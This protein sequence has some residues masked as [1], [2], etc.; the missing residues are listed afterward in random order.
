MVRCCLWTFFCYSLHFVY[1]FLLT[2]TIWPFK[3]ASNPKFANSLIESDHWQWN[4]DWHLCRS[5][6]IGNKILTLLAFVPAKMTSSL[7]LAYMMMPIH[8]K[9]SVRGEIPYF[10][11]C[12]TPHHIEHHKC[13][14]LHLHP[15]KEKVNVKANNETRLMTRKPQYRKITSKLNV[16][17][18]NDIQICV[19]PFGE[20]L[21]R[22]NRRKRTEAH[23]NPMKFA[24]NG[25]AWPNVCLFMMIQSNF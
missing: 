4:T 24:M 22:E 23:K 3:T 25:S 20:M 7:T 17:R 16:K 8:K 21:I 1:K 15:L 10:M 5:I 12:C 14:H 13:S 18:K 2:N 9:A 19:F 11:K 6:V